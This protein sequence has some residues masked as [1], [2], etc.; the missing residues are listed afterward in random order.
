L[1]DN[2]LDI[3]YQK[4]QVVT[5]FTATQCQRI[6][7]DQNGTTFFKPGEYA[8]GEVAGNLDGS[9]LTMMSSGGLMFG[10]INIVGNFGTVFCDNAYWQSAIAARPTSAHKG[11]LLGGIAWFAIPFSLATAMG[12]YAAA[13]QL[14]IT[15]AEA[16]AGLVPPAVATHL[17]GKGGALMMTIM[18]FNAITSTGSAEALAV[19]S[20]I[21]YDVYKAYV[22]P[23]ASDKEL[24]VLS[25]AVIIMFGGSMGGLAVALHAIGLDLNFVYLFMGILI[26][27][28][29]IPLWNMLMW[30]KANATGAIVAAWGGMTLAIVVWLVAAKAWY[31]EVTLA[32]LARNEPMLAGNLTAICS[33]GII[34]CSFSIISPQNYDFTSMGAV[35]AVKASS[36][37]AESPDQSLHEAKAWILKWGVGFSFG[38]AVCLPLLCLCVGVFDKVLF[39][40]WVILSVVWGCLAAAVIIILPLWES[41]HQLAGIVRAMLGRAHAQ[42]PPPS[43]KSPSQINNSDEVHSNV[44]DSTVDTGSVV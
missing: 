28:A 14:P 2:S 22:N 31:D 9:Y 17:F 33:S 4:L 24:L 35:E 20:L 40:A 27:S 13:M 7:T 26:G 36:C 19:S 39:C 12:L 37:S 5:R 3:M 25:R 29:V 18:L 6:F 15:A 42:V 34:H 38:V 16:A 23:R 8:C 10:I 21:V 32:T 11:Y 44:T 43:T 41:R 30:R 1:Q